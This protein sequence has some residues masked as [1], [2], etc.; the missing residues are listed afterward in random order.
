MLLVIMFAAGINSARGGGLGTLSNVVVAGPT[1]VVGNSTTSSAVGVV[2]DQRKTFHA[3]GYFWVFY[4]NG[5]DFVYRR[6]STGQEN[7]WG[8]EVLV[9]SSVVDGAAQI[10]LTFN[11]SHVHYVV[12]QSSGSSYSMFYRIG[13]PCSDGMI[14]WASEVTVEGGDP[15]NFYSYPVIVTDTGGHVWVGANRRNGTSVQ[16]YPQILKNA[17]VDGTWSHASGFPYNLTST[18]ASTWRVHPVPLTNEKMYVLYDYTGGLVWGKLYNG[19]WGNEETASAYDV[20]GACAVSAVNKDDD[21]HFSYSATMDGNCEIHYR[22]RDYDA[23]PE[24]STEQAIFTAVSWFSGIPTLCTVSSTGDLYCFWVDVTNN[25]IFYKRFA[26]GVWDRLPKHWIIEET[27]HITENDRISCY[28]QSYD[29]MIGVVYL[30]GLTSPYRIKHSFLTLTGTFMRSSNATYE[31]TGYTNQRKC[32]YA[33]SRHWVFYADGGNLVYQC[34]TDGWGWTNPTKVHEGNIN[35]GSRFSIYY[36]GTFLHCVVGPE[37]NGLY[38]R[39]GTPNQDGSIA[40]ADSEQQVLSSETTCNKPIISVDAE[41]HPWIGYYLLHSF[42]AK[43]ALSNGTWQ[44]ASDFPC[45][46]GVDC[47]DVAPI[48]LSNGN[49]YVI[50]SYLGQQAKA[51]LYDGTWGD[52]QTITDYAV[53]Y[54]E[55]LSWATEGNN[56]H[57]AYLRAGVGEI[58]YKK[59]SQGGWTTE[60]SVQGNAE[61]ASSPSI[62]LSGSTPVVFWGNNNTIA[63]RSKINETWS[64]QVILWDGVNLETETIN[65]FESADSGYIG[66]CWTNGTHNTHQVRYSFITE[67]T[68]NPSVLSPD[69]EE[70]WSGTHSVIWT[71]PSNPDQD[72]TSYEIQ[73]SCDSGTTW[74]TLVN[75][76]VG[77]SYSWDT[78][79][80]PDG[81]HYLVRLR[82]YHDRISSCW[83]ESDMEFTIDNSPP[84]TSI[85]DLTTNDSYACFHWF[86]SDNISSPSELE[87][88]YCLAGYNN[89]WSSWTHNLTKEYKEL[90]CGNFTFRVKARDT[91]WNEDPTPAER[92]FT[93][94]S[95]RILF[96]ASGLPNGA[97]LAFTVNDVSHTGIVPFTY[98]ERLNHSA[99]VSFNA[100]SQVFYKS[101]AQYFLTGWTDENNN[102]VSSPVLVTEQHTYTAIYRMKDEGA[103][104]LTL[105]DQAYKPAQN[106]QVYL[107]GNYTGF[108]NSSGMLLLQNVPTGSHLLKAVKTGYDDALKAVY[109]SRGT[110][111]DI[112]M[113][114]NVRTVTITVH[115]VDPIGVDVSY[116]NVYVGGLYRGCTDYRGLFKM[117]NFPSGLCSIK[118]MKTG[119]VDTSTT[120]NATDDMSV[121]ITLARPPVVTVSATD[122]NGNAI[123]SASVYL[124]G[125]YIGYTN[126][127]GMCRMTNVMLGNQTFKVSKSGYCDSS[128]TINVTG[129]MSFN[130][131]LIKFP[132]VTVYVTDPTS[133]IVL[134]A[135]VSFNGTSKG[136]T[137]S[138]GK[139]VISNVPPGNY[140]L[141]ATKSGYAE[142]V[143]NITVIADMTI[144]ITLTRPLT[145]TA[146]VK[147]STGANISSASVYLD[148]T[149][150]G[151][152]DYGGKCTISNVPLGGCL[153]KVAKSGYVDYTI[154]LAITSDIAFN[155]T[156]LRT[157]SLTINVK[158]ASNGSSISYVDVYLDDVYVGKT[159]YFGKATVANVA[160]GPH[161]LTVKK[162]GYLDYSAS[163]NVT[164][165]VTLA[166]PL[167]KA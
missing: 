166:I 80:Y 147:D 84:D 56:I 118:I 125:L 143:A 9:K 130:V 139:L 127:T 7:S 110:N 132:V 152:T 30:V 141:R 154:N 46:I 87:Y 45:D 57:L 140:T 106:A 165:S 117:S 27:N 161:T 6:S 12:C 136:S 92:S 135:S 153:L 94:V 144:N 32:F 88:S 31:A 148:G 98:S 89:G 102:A 78:T 121:N 47:Y 146:Y 116:A 156:L 55:T 160:E 91:A 35:S 16:C 131:R 62:T 96:G 111:V 164:S 138:S 99:L 20:D 134:Y 14:S 151:A 150:K 66:L 113:T 74:H 54:C 5:T 107:D 124:G 123:F 85:V 58:R 159:D 49:M 43:S 42:V 103:L 69:G 71:A 97:S 65:A 38:Y 90:S 18:G 119:Y 81:G 149:Y 13:Q 40:W 17:N 50:Y 95:L 15:G 25:G 8:N 48:P 142:Y 24:W 29:N 128:K 112:T 44:N 126:S 137:N 60:E 70:K 19:T 122:L 53:Q 101:G 167:I 163:I 108:T 162:T 28:Y 79:S 82:A 115:V 2:G 39:M 104:I 3:S 51:R 86:G 10:A 36:D 52:Q 145:L 1:S 133:S 34:S 59:Y 93:V 77:N 83:D 158:D 157:Y 11:G 155:A 37:N 68:A 75:E 76:T 129:D 21:V 41:G 22:K 26:C 114:M 67:T 64:N 4:S 100:S 33:A 109:V 120:I 72:L 63:Y 105:K 23:Q 61:N 73:Y